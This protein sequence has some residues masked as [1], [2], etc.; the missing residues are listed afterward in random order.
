MNSNFNL[1]QKRSRDEELTYTEINGDEKKQKMY[2]DTAIYTVGN[3]IHF[4]CDINKT[5][6]Q[7]IIKQITD[8]ITEHE[9]KHGQEPFNLVYVVD[10]PGG[11]VTS[12]LKFVDFIKRTKEKY[13]YVKFVSVISGMV[14]SAGTIMAI[15]ADE[16]IMTKYSHAMIH[17]LSSGTSNKYTHFVSYTKFLTTLHNCLVE[18]YCNKSKLDKD[19]VEKYLNGETWFSAEEYKK[20]NFVDEIK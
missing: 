1:G 8:V 18:I 5:S 15:V 20:L 9:K 3:E 14:A 17:E 11:S 16:R 19:T 2:L 13:P 10:S 6:I 7:V 12:V 4:T